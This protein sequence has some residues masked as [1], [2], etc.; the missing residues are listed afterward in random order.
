MRK[1]S[2]KGAADLASELA[3][4]DTVGEHLSRGHVAGA[5]PGRVESAL[6]DSEMDGQVQVR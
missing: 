4:L 1:Q 3:S 2:R 5:A 6:R